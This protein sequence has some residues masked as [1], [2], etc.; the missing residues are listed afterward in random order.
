VSGI[1]LRATPIFAGADENPSA[2]ENP[3][4]RLLPSPG[5]TADARR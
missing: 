3:L 2:S 5:A 1:R 4:H